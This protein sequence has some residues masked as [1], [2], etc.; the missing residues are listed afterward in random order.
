MASND[1]VRR[2]REE[3]RKRRAAATAKISR[4]RR[5]HGADIAGT[6]VDPRR[7][8]KVINK[9]NAAQLRAYLGKIESFMDRKIQFVGGARGANL[10]KS[11]VTDLLKTQTNYNK[12]VEA[13]R[14]EL[15]KINI[16]GKGLNI[17]QRRDTI[18]PTAAG[19]VVN[20][21]YAKSNL[22][23]SQFTSDESVAKMAAQL[24]ERMAP[25]YLAKKL[26]E[27]R[28]QGRQMLV[29]MGAHDLIDEMNDLTDYQFDILW[30]EAGFAQALSVVYTVLESNAGRWQNSVVED[31]KDDIRE[32]LG[33]AATLEPPQR[34]ESSENTGLTR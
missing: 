26:K 3:V 2:L 15:D 4:T 25:D 22:K 23:P 17:G 10:K 6:S 27:A 12:V 7:D 13:R 9:Y 14:R 18:H 34:G 28:E 21:P 31:K 29:H 24:K 19:S 8:P 11:P 20:D 33:W 5:V 32:F 30:N 16:L 1:E